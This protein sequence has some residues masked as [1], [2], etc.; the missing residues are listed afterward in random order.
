[1]NVTVYAGPFCGVGVYVWEAD[2]NESLGDPAMAYVA[3]FIYI[4]IV[5]FD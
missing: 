5:Y 2:Q 4:Y 1:M 3:L